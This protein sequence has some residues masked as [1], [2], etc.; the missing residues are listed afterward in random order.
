MISSKLNNDIGSIA[1]W[2][3][4]IRKK[5]LVLTTLEFPNNDQVRLLM[6]RKHLIVTNDELV[7]KFNFD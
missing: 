7:R 5:Y 3:L 1:E 4:K 6:Q 2:I